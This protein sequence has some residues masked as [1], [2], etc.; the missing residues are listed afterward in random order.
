MK[1]QRKNRKKH[2][3]RKNTTAGTE[4]SIRRSQYI[5]AAIL[6]SSCLIAVAAVVPNT[7]KPGDSAAAED[8][9]A[10]FQALAAA[11]STAEKRIDTLEAKLA[12]VSVL[13]YNGHPTLRFSGVNVQV[14]NGEGATNTMNGTGNLIIGYDET[15]TSDTNRCSQGFDPVHGVYLTLS[16]CE[17]NGY[18]LS[19][20]GFK[21]GSHYLVVGMEN[22]YSRWGGIVAG[23]QNTVSYDFANVIGGY[24][25]SATGPYATVFG[26]RGNNAI[27]YVSSVTGGLANEA[28]GPYTTING[29][30]SN[31]GE[32]DYATVLGGYK[33]VASGAHASV[34]GGQTCNVSADYGW[35]VGL[36]TAGCSGTL[37]NK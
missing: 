19:S 24:A 35:Q 20:T 5:G 23:Y 12:S 3:L 13:D 27:S 34:S 1:A 26:G 8:V 30:Q 16:N 37:I 9:N 4:R 6:A 21:T 2:H 14:V 25:N 36:T 22:N 31:A 33:N 11:L 17:S 28:R 18:T 15:D 10:N 7:F 29:G 32:G